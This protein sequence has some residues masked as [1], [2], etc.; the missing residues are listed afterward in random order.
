ME[1]RTAIPQ[2]DGLGE[3]PFWHPLERRLY[4]IDIPGRQVRRADPD[5]GAVESW[6]VPSEPG[7]IAP[8]EGGGLVI[9][10]R[11]GIYR[12]PVWRG[13]VQPLAR[14]G[15]DPRTTRARRER[16]RFPDRKSVV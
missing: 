7:C 8:L 13:Q 10:L 14:L 15:Y 1:W 9:A 16:D 3:S 2:R 4:W 11:E 6:E 5:T 12:A